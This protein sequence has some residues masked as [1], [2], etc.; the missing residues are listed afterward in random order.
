MLFFSPLSPR[1]SHSIAMLSFIWE[2][3]CAC[4]TPSDTIYLIIIF[5]LLSLSNYIVNVAPNKTNGNQN[6]YVRK[7]KNFW[8]ERTTSW[9]SKFDTLEPALASNDLMSFLLL[10]LIHSPPSVSHSQFLMHVFYLLRGG[11]LQKTFTSKH[12]L[13]LYSN[14]LPTMRVKLIGNE[15][16]EIV[17]MA[18]RYK[19]L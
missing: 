12:F 2:N 5:S 10:R 16:V 3:V 8:S 1:S 4:I 6:G 18:K 7:K 9:R 11:V 17:V 13:L 14:L 19:L 15:L